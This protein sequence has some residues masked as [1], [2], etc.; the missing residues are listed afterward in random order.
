MESIL[1]SVKEM[2]G[3]AE[4]YDVF[5]TVIA[6][7]INSV[8]MILRQ[9][10]VGPKN[11]FSIKDATATWD[12]FLQ[13]TDDYESVKTYVYLKV[14]LLFDPPLSTAVTEAIKQMIAEL[15]WR[16]NFEAELNGG[17]NQNV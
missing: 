1:T 11:G 8:F 13:G 12:Q 10:G 7:H 16:L 9:I 14:K 15:E 17:K 5:D 4:E 2:L 6:M 3:I